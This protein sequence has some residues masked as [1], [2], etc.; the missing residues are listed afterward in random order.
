MV[1]DSMRA[2]FAHALAAPQ[3]GTALYGLVIALKAQGVAQVT[4]MLLFMEHQL[5]TEADD[6]NYD[7]IVDMMDLIQSGPWAKGHGLFETEV[8][9]E[10]IR[11]AQDHQS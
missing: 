2:R 7:A 10:Q 8:T 5:Q 3:P 6:P 9:A 4:I 11:R 1:T